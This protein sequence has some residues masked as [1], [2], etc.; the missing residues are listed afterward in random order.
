LT[1]TAGN[2]C[3]ISYAASYPA[4]WPACFACNEVSDHCAEILVIYTK[5]GTCMLTGFNPIYA[6]EN[7]HCGGC[8]VTHWVYPWS[9]DYAY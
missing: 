4:S 6:L 3:S 5:D 2:T 1:A 9:E 8:P 7:P